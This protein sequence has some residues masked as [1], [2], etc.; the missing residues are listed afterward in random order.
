MSLSSLYFLIMAWSTETPCYLISVSKYKEAKAIYARLRPHLSQTQVDLEFEKMRLY[1]DEERQRRKTEEWS[2]FIRSKSIRRPLLTATLME[3]FVYTTGIFVLLNFISNVIP[4]NNYLSKK[5]YPMIMTSVAMLGNFGSICVLDMLPRRILYMF[6]CIVC[7]V[8]QTSNAVFQYLY[9][10]Y[11]VL[12]CFWG[13]VVGNLI[14]RVLWSVLLIPLQ[15]TVKSEIFPQ[16]VR[17]LGGSLCVM[18]CSLSNILT[19]Q[20]YDIVNFNMH[21]MY[22]FF[23]FAN[24]TLFF[25]VYTRLP[26]G[27]GMCLEDIQMKSSNGKERF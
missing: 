16:A 5:Y 8:V 17:G 22:V 6:A 12:D 1:I 2:T 3:F 19:Y 15:F 25:I 7:F 10:E 4:N 9:V 27:R 18:A 13:I 24:L 26:E 20:L 21:Y 14:V 11:K 23:A